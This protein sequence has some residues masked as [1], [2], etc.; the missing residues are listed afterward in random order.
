MTEPA[1][2]ETHEVTTDT[3]L[4]G[5]LLTTESITPLNP[6]IN[7]GKYEHPYQ[8]EDL[9]LGRNISPKKPNQLI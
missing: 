1:D 4:T 5:T 6:R 9:N 8:V 7:L 2:L 3:L